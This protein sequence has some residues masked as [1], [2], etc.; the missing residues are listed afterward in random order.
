MSHPRH[1]LDAVIHNP[2]RFSIMAALLPAD[3]VEFRFVRETVEI[4]D[5]VLSQ[6]VTTLE[7]AGYVKVTKGQVGRRPRT[8]LAAT[9]AGRRAFAKHL[10]VLNQLAAGPSAAPGS[11]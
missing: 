2:T 10:D 11:N 3:K 9:R 1:Q 4:T 8:W 7:E 6:H 5:S